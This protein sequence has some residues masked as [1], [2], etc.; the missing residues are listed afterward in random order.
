MKREV[1]AMKIEAE[2]NGDLAVIHVDWAEQHKLIEMS[3]VQS[4]YF[5]GRRHYDIHTGYVY[6]KEDSHGIASISDCPDHKAEAVHAAIKGEIVKLKEKGKTTIVIV[7]DS[8]TSQYRN[9]K[10]VFLMKR[11]A[12][13]LEICIRLLFTESGHG[14]SPCDGVGGNIKTQV[15]EVML[16]NH[17]EKEVIQ[18]ESVEDIKKLIETKTRLTYDIS[19]HTAKDIEEVKESLPKLGPLVGAMKIHEVLIS[20]SG[21]IKKK[22]LPSDVFYQHV[23]IKESRRHRRVSGNV[24]HDEDSVDEYSD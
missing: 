19:I 23:K 24:E 12:V 4:A 3:E 5:N 7:S 15:E 6:C 22:N 14:K 13:E 1:K 10:N 8:P 21:I 11:L 18:I 2:E 16:R 20:S 17:G 9:S